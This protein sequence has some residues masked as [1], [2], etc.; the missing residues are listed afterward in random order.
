MQRAT[1]S[2]R[3]EHVAWLGSASLNAGYA[4]R[5]TRRRWRAGR[6]RQQCHGRGGNGDDSRSRPGPHLSWAVQGNHRRERDKGNARACGLSVRPAKKPPASGEATRACRCW[7]LIHPAACMLTPIVDTRPHAHLTCTLL[8]ATHATLHTYTHTRARA[9]VHTLTH[10][11]PHTHTRTR[12][13]TVLH[14]CIQVRQWL[15]LGVDPNIGDLDD[16][17][18]G[19]SPLMRAAAY[20]RSEVRSACTSSRTRIR[21]YTRTC[22]Q[23]W[24]TLSS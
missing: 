13:Q 18:E 7:L 15:A 8:Y 6:S 3:H 17:D 23:R 16:P 19:E 12:T 10:P 1:R 11:H 2:V 20:D 14:A 5:L 24:Q 4:A 9:R 21:M 22:C